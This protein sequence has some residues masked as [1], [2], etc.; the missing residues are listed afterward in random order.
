MNITGGAAIG[1]VV[2]FVVT[3]NGNKAAAPL[4]VSLSNT[5][6]FEFHSADCQGVVLAIGDSCAIEVRP[7]ALDNGAYIGDLIIQS[8]STVTVNLS[9]TATGFPIPFITVWR[10]NN[11]GTTNAMTI[12]LPL[13]AT[14]TYNFVVD[15]GD[16]STSTVTSA[17]DPDITHSYSVAG[18]YTVKMRGQYSNLDSFSSP[19]P[20]KLLEITQW[21]D[22]VW[23]SM[24]N[25]FNNCTD[26]QIT[27]TDTPD[28]SNVINARAMFDGATSFNSNINNWDVSHI[29]NMSY[30]FRNTTNYNQN[31]NSWDVSSVTNM[32][33]M[34]ASATSFKGNISDWDVSNVINMQ[35]MFD[36]ATAFDTDISHWD[37]SSLEN[38]S[39]MFYRASN[40]NAPINYDNVNNYW[41]TSNVKNMSGT[42][43]FSNFN[44]N[45]NLWNTSNV[46]S[47]AGMFQMNFSFDQPLNNWVTSSVTDMSNMFSMAMA[48]NQ[49]IS[50]W[51]TG[52]V[53]NMDNMF[54]NAFSFNQNLTGWS[55]AGSPSHAGFDTGAPA[56]WTQKPAF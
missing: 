46:T 54:Q 53:T 43:Y 34:F 11:P 6:N 4:T 15:W 18:D 33:S 20:R 13:E 19:N 26:L 23:T 41:N 35:T 17:A 29:E 38:M 10:T 12:T 36:S 52:S 22:N 25:A 48:F 30:M 14:G 32:Q 27:A 21:G 50:G 39:Y 56:G 2:N 31:M 8:D 37:T 51:Q 3:N 40:F 28:L 16:G 24:E 1:S 44:Q 42:F 55:T 9:G 49:N 5:N 47:M 45:I 7:K